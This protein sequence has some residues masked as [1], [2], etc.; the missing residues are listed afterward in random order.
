MFVALPAGAAS[1]GQLDPVFDKIPFHKWVE[2]GEPAKIK[3]S[4][5]IPEPI[6]SAHQRLMATARLRIDGRT[7]LDMVGKGGLV[8]FL[9]V[10]DAAGTIWQTHSVYDLTKADEG[11]KSRDV[12]YEQSFF[13]L[14]G[15]YDVALVALD[16]VSGDHSV[17]RH[18]LHVNAMKNDPLADSWRTL[19]PVELVPV[20]EGADAAYLSGI[21][22]RLALEAKPNGPVA[23]DIVLNLT[24]T[25]RLEASNV[26]RGS[27]FGV[28][29]PALKVL[30]GTNW[31]AAKVRVSFLDLQQRK[32]TFEQNGA[33]E[34][35]WEKAREALDSKTTGKV[36]VKML[37]NRRFAAQFFTSELAK[38]I[39]GPAG[40]AK[41][42]V[43]RIV[44]VLST[45]VSFE[46]GVERHPIEAAPAEGSH[47]YYVRYH[48]FQQKLVMVNPVEQLRRGRAPIDTVEVQGGPQWAQFD[49]LAGLLKAI[50]PDVFDVATPE[51][52][53]KTL[54]TI[55]GE[56][57]RM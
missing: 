21:K 8:I 23:L 7:L 5:E 45:P 13:V 2:A 42:A 15:D 54:G 4:F 22:G 49:Q 38:R 37:E 52:F 32:V 31:G 12:E 47:V 44:I 25:E 29:L 6:L 9:E 35:D 53:R 27:G 16:T 56:I 17:A 33:G 19:P 46:R 34:L 55:L 10:R 43:R 11:V 18:R 50:H 3:A 39:E 36:D 48:P 30:A 51:Q 40:E 57:G 14:P 20:A 24:P 28:L 26:G 41:S 1:G